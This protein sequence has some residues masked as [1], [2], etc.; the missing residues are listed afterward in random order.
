MAAPVNSFKAGLK[1]GKQTIG[2]WLTQG[3]AVAAEIAAQEQQMKAE[4][5]RRE[6]QRREVESQIRKEY[7]KS[8][9]EAERAKEEAAARERAAAKAMEDSIRSEMQGKFELEERARKAA[10]E[11]L[12]RCS[13][14][15]TRC[16][17][18]A[19]RYIYHAVSRRTLQL[20]HAERYI[21]HAV[22]C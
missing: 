11:E 17:Y 16:I 19:E 8:R 6:A 14:C 15:T 7:E 20:S 13:S 5:D 4:E 10:W 3:T 2:S 9:L 21:Y 12:S 18:H 1:A 22:P